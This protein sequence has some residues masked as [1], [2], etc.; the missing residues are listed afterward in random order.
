MRARR[1]PPGRGRAQEEKEFMGDSFGLVR[2]AMPDGRGNSRRSGSFRSAKMIK[3]IKQFSI[4][5]LGLAAMTFPALR[6]A[7]QDAPAAAKQETENEVKYIQAPGAATAGAPVSITLQDAMARARKLD[8]TL[9]GAMSDAKSAREDRLQARNAM[10]PNLTGESAY[11]NTQGNGGRVSDGRFV[12]NDGVHIYREWLVYHQDLSPGVLMGTGYT[13]AKAAEALSNAKS[14]I[15]RR[16]LSVTVTKAYYSLV[17]AQRKFAA[18]QAGLDQAKHF[19]DITG[20]LEHQGQSPHSDQIKAEIA[21]RIQKQAY[22]EAR[23]AMEDTRLGLGVILFPEFNVNFTVVDD[24]DAPPAL[25]PFAD[26]QTLAEKQNPDLRVALETA[27]EA[28]LDVKL[29]KQAYL[30]TITVEADNGIEANCFALHC[31]RAA[32]PEVGPLPNLGYFLTATL[33]VPVWDWGTL[34]SKIHQA[35]YKQEAAKTSLTLAQRTAI[36]ELYATYDEAM[37]AQGALDEAKHTAELATESLRLTS[38]R[39]QGGASLASEVVDAETTLV[40][41]QNAYADAQVRYR[42]LLATLQTFTGSF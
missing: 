3:S 25:P 1:Y 30:P 32:F 34:R 29:A 17:V 15:A 26:V 39:Y 38:L 12:T 42:T 27:H 14:E 37:V 36:S 4:L 23:F 40:T 6:A 9:V 10:L 7:A 20:N 28:E 31:T 41:A 18:A 21:Y 35:E 13:R 33:T 8:P 22:D 16:G 5:G 24:L 2:T 11:L 19:M